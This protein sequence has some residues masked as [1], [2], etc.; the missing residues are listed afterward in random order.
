M[1]QSQFCPACCTVTCARAPRHG[2]SRLRKNRTK[3]GDGVF[4]IRSLTRTTP[5]ETNLRYDELASGATVWAYQGNPWGEQ[6]PTSNS[7]YVLNLRFPG[8]YYD[9]EDG[10]NYNGPRYYESAK[11][12]FDQ[13][14]PIGQVGGIDL[15]VYGLNSPLRYI[16]PS[17]LFP[18]P[19]A[20]EPVDADGTP[21]NE[22]MRELKQDEAMKKDLELADQYE[23]EGP[24]EAFAPSEFSPVGVCKAKGSEPTESEVGPPGFRGSKGYPLRNPAYQPR[25]N[26]PGSVGDVNY[27]GHAF[28]QMQNRGF[29]PSVVS[30]AI[31]NGEPFDAGNGATGYYD[32]VNNISVIVNSQTGTIV[33]VRPGSP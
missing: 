23:K 8:Q 6:Q 22:G 32:P 29:M 28:D 1:R 33:T 24:G 2:N 31:Q 17:G 19:P 26:Q 13:P 30:N 25:R 3:Q 10:L 9:A 14:D 20:E 18:E 5:R 7:G 27:S 12:G 11:G 16:D 21:A 15:Y 4:V